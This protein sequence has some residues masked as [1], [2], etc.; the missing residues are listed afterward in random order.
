MFDTDGGALPGGARVLS[1]LTVARMTSPATPANEP[2][3]RGLGWDMD[4]SY[5]ANRGELLPLGSFG[6]TGFTGTSLWIDPRNDLYVVYTHNW[7][8]DP[9]LAR[10]ATLDRRIAS[11]ILFTH[12]F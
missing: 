2:N 11:K 12:R 1:P 3:V 6:H 9:G 7:L 5:S 4:S 8:D 10:F